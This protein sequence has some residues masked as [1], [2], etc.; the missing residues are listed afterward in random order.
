MSSRCYRDIL[1]RPEEAKIRGSQLFTLVRPILV[2][3]VG[4]HQD[5]RCAMNG[6]LIPNIRSQELEHPKVF[7]PLPFALGRSLTFT[8]NRHLARFTFQPLSPSLPLPLK[9]T[10]SPNTGNPF[11]F[12]IHPFP[13]LLSFTFPFSSSWV[14]YLGFNSTMVQ[15]PLPQGKGQFKD[16]EVGT[17]TWKASSPVLRSPGARGCWIDLRQNGVSE[18]DGRE[19]RIEEN[20]WPEL[21]RWKVGLW[22]EDAVLTLGEP[23]E[24][25]V[26]NV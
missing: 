26:K 4:S 22:L 9:I 24:V 10:I 1:T 25:K 2:I 14:S 12:T 3:M 16:I 11:T 15:P 23:E 19:I 13:S 7:H 6:Y 21:G 5:L 18:E 20:W 17:E 8:T